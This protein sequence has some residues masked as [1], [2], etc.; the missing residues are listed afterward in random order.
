MSAPAKPARRLDAETAAD[1]AH[2]PFKAD[3]PLL[4]SNPDLAFLDSAATAQRP[5][6]VLDAQRRFYEAKNANALRGLYR[7]SVDATE[8]IEAA[9]SRVARFIGAAHARD[10]VFCRNTSEALNLVAASFGGLVLKPGDEVCLTIM[11]HHSNLVPWQQACRRAGATLVFL[12]P[13]ENGVVTQAE[14]DAKIGPKTKIVAAAQVSNVLGIENP[15]R[16]MGER[17]HA[18]GGYLVVDGA[19]SA[20]H[21]PIDV[22]AIGCDFFAF[23]AHKAFG[24]FGIGVLWGR[25]ELLDAMPPFLTG[26]EM[27]EYVTEQDATWAPV[28]EKF[29]AGTQDAAGI[30]ATAAALD[31]LDGIGLDVV[32]AREQALV[33]YL[34]ARLAELPYVRVLGHPSPAHHHGVVS[35]VVDGIHPHDVASLLDLENV[36]IRAGNH[37]AQPLITWL[38]EESTCRASLALYNDQSDIDRL[39]AALK[40]TWTT[41]NPESQ[42]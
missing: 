8:A 10:I 26:G 5:A 30:V 14:M 31:Y 21:L 3:F 33:A 39:I 17:V 13:D 22:E 16:E 36:A 12:Y 20:P 18:H 2:N 38:G 15:V 42:K 9:R 35:F 25:D 34:M 32:H 11:E 37:C 19:Q 6:C 24:P 28:P 4:E 40:T 41:F 23:S 7:L 27:I 1:I 29:E